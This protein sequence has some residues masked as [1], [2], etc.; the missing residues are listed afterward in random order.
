MLRSMVRF[1]RWQLG[2][3]L[4]SGAVVHEWVNGSK[5]LVRK[6]ETGLTGNVYCGLHEFSDMGFLLHFLRDSDL[7]VD[8]GANVGS[9]TI[10]ACAAVGAAG[11]A[12][13]PIPG[14]YTRLV[15]NLRLNNLDDRVTPV[16]MG[17]GAS[18]GSLL[19][20]SDLDCVNHA[21]AAGEVQEDA[22]RVEVTTL[23]AA[24]A[25]KA[26]ILIKIDV[27]GFETPVLEGATE[28][29]SSLSL[30][31]V[32]MELN[33]SGARYGYDE[34]RILRW[35]LDAGF[36]TYTYDPIR[37]ELNAL[38]GKNAESGN[39]LF[40]RDLEFVKHRLATAPAVSLQGRHF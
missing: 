27:E 24:L 35:M 6:G 17:V 31:A 34:G 4:I 28:T 10:L 9:Y 18:A 8:V 26:P 2:S 15:G 30:K 23:D 14:T 16:N 1:L 7:F 11:V 37:R 3:R 21:L 32:I 36:E 19:F 38:E 29:L 40:I 33:G 13:E 25:D 12:F 5:F 39:T 22:T 20:T